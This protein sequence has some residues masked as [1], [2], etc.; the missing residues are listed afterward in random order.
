MVA[1]PISILASAVLTALLV[2]SGLDWAYFTWVQSQPLTGWL[3]LAD[4]LGYLVPVVLPLGLLG[5]GLLHRRR[6]YMRLA[7]A[8]LSAAIGAVVVA[9]A[10]KSLT[11]R[12]SPPHHDFGASLIGA[13]NSA[14][15]QFG[16]MRQS[17][18]G[19]WPSSHALVSF[20]VL[21][22][23]TRLSP[24]PLPVV[25][26]GLPL[27][28]FIGLGV[29]FG[30]HWLSEFASGALIGSAVGLWVAHLVKPA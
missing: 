11:G 1:I 3:H 24:R 5:L 4:R 22:A 25:L 8:A 10:L 26:I 13:D 29:S 27:A 12:V 30:F 18:L 21:L 23:L 16:F 20:A 19:G 14:A 9:I 6:P 2:W 28:L 17:V 15:F 7:L